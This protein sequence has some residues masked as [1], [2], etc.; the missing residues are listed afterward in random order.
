MGEIKFVVSLVLVA[1]FVIAIISY[2][3]NYMTE[4]NSTISLDDDE[5]FSTLQTNTKSDL[6]TFK[7]NVNSS[8]EAFAESEITAEQETTR[9]GG[10]FKVG[11]GTLLS[12]IK[13]V[14]DLGR[15][16]IFG[17]D[18]RF[19]VVLTALSS[20]LVYIG[21]RYVWKTWAGKNPD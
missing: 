13:S 18:V 11:M 9:T 8:S 5:T 3:S 15:E 19:A 2:T 10:Q 17:G 6:T 21:F 12:S 14:F 16:K 1:L 4:N 7:T 20:L